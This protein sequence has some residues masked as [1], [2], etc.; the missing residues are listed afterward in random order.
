MV[1]QSFETFSTAPVCEW[2]VIF[3]QMVNLEMCPGSRV[4]NRQYLELPIPS[5]GSRNAYQPMQPTKITM[6]EP[7]HFLA[8]QCGCT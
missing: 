3:P 7:S 2:T 1:L 4:E 5:H 8:Q 6:V